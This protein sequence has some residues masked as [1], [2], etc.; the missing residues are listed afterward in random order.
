MLRLSRPWTSEDDDRIRSLSASGASAVRA[1][2]A[3]KPTNMPSSGVPESS[4][5]LSKQLALLGKNGPTRPTI[6]G[7]AKVRLIRLPHDPRDPPM[8]VR[9]NLYASMLLQILP[10]LF[11]GSLSFIR[12]QVVSSFRRAGHI[13]SECDDL[14]MRE[15]TVSTPAAPLTIALI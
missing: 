11:C 8:V 12:D 9:P 13:D 10:G 7:V 4:A 14:V 15:F 1:S 5:V 2:A 3:L 6:L